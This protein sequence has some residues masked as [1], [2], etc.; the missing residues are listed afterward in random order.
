VKTNIANAALESAKSLGLPTTAADERRRDT[1]NKKL[2][3]M[4][5]ARAAQIILDGVEANRPRILVG[6]DAKLVDK[7]VR[8]VPGRAVKLSVAFSKRQG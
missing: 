2:L 7:L 1:Y 6:N 3:R 8:L 4:D 5:P